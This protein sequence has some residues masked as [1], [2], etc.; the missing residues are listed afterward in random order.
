MQETGESYLVAQEARMRQALRQ[1]NARVY[2]LLCDD[3]GIS[4]DARNPHLYRE[5]VI[6][7]RKLGQSRT[8]LTK[9]RYEPTSRGQSLEP[10][11][12][13]DV[14]KVVELVLPRF[15]NRGFGKSGLT[16]KAVKGRLNELKE[17]GYV[18]PNF[19]GMVRNEVVNL[20]FQ[21]REEVYR[22]GISEVPGLVSKINDSNRVRKSFDVADRIAA[23]NP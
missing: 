9:P 20:W 4:Q 21:I 2:A 6:L 7:N 1:G 13:Y 17:I 15:P 3:L 8:S 10:K 12:G 16:A 19:K 23:H 11:L 5:G 22:L 14:S 18:V